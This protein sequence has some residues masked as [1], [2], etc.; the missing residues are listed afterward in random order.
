LTLAYQEQ[1]PD[2]SSALKRVA[3]LR[4]LSRAGKLALIARAGRTRVAS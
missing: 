3:A 4:R 2:R 1:Q